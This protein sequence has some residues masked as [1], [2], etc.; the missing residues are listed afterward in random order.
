[1]FLKG[2]QGG[3][4]DSMPKSISSSNDAILSHL[5]ET[6]GPFLT[7]TNMT[8]ILHVSRPN[9]DHLIATGD[10]PAA[11]IGRQYRVKTDDFVKWWNG[12]VQQTQ[13]N[14]LKGCLPG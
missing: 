1:M 7:V 5:I 6:Y 11:K 14:I 3:L 8:E 4:P 2:G 10:L 12:R 13:K 9:I